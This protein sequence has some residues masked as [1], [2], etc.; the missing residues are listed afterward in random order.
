MWERGQEAFVHRT[1]F[2]W[3]GG[4]GGWAGGWVENEAGGMSCCLVQVFVLGGVRG[5]VGGRT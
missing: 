2:V 1:P 3:G 5:G 4:V